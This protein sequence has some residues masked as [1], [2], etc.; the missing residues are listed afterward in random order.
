M[1]I[2]PPRQSIGDILGQGLSDIATHWAE[3]RTTSK[4]LK[5]LGFSDAQAKAYA[6][7]SPQIQQ[8]AV[9]A[10]QQQQQ[11]EASNAAINQILGLGLPQVQ[12][13]PSFSGPTAGMQQQQQVPMQMQPRQL[14][15]EQAIQQATSIAQN[16]AFRKL[17]EQQQQAQALQ[18]QQLL[19]GQP[20]PQRQAPIT[21][22]QQA[23]LQSQA[24]QARKP[25]YEDKIAQINRQRQALGAMPLNTNDRFKAEALLNSAED[26]ALKEEQHR[27]KQEDKRSERIEKREDTLRKDLDSISKRAERA[28]QDIHLLKQIKAAN[29]TG[30]LIQGPKRRLLEDLG[31]KY[32]YNFQDYFTNPTTENAAKLVE[33]MQT[34]A[35]T[36]FGTGRL[37]NF[38][39]EAYGKSLP[40]LANS[41]E[42][43]DV[44]IKNLIL[45]DKGHIALNDEIRKIKA[46][47]RAANQILPADI[48]DMARERVQPTLDKYAEE[49][50][51]NIDTAVKRQEAFAAGKIK[52][53]DKT[54]N[55][56]QFPNG[57]IG[58]NKK[59]G[60]KLIAK[61]G[62]W[63]PYKG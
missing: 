8:Q 3:H 1:I 18:N 47:Y 56:S 35:G 52:K 58:N 4:A 13:Q 2:L 9:H 21:G 60:Q 33:R 51:G 59:T 53:F 24:Q 20:N 62:K 28:H 61:D 14:P 16:P 11:Q 63:V 48:E 38:I 12:P 42:G 55:A 31:R 26:R 43:M 44:I 5:D 36:A 7:L 17:N 40:R 27:Q 57:T 46:E 29:D 10:R 25:T 32:G 45:E 22:E 50:L 34:G 49:A 30:T 39:A 19:T 6:N 54:P 15:Q 23:I 37:T 41:Q